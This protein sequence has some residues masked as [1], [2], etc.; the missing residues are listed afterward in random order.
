M[1]IGLNDIELYIDNKPIEQVKTVKF[2]GVNIDDDIKWK[3]HVKKISN[4]ISRY[5]GVLNRLR[6]FVPQNILLMLYNA[7]ILPNLNYG[8]ILWGS[9][10]KYLLE[11]LLKLHKRIVRIITNSDFRSHS[12]PLSKKLHIL[13]VYKLHNYNLGIFMFLYNKNLLPKIFN[14]IFKKKTKAFIVTIREID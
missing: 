4:Q 13:T 3:S 7:L 2:L 9:S 10:N 5:I 14:S 8:I 11:S 1:H 12:M 6:E